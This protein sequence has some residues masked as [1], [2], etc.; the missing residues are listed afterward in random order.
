MLWFVVVTLV[1]LGVCAVSQQEY[2]SDEAAQQYQ[3]VREYLA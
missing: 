2:K 1:V 3:L